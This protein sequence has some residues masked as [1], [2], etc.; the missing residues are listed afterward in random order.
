MT[1]LYLYWGDVKDDWFDRGYL[2]NTDS[3]VFITEANNYVTAYTYNNNQVNQSSAIV[4]SEGNQT[5]AEMPGNT[6]LGRSQISLA[7]L[8]I[9]NGNE[10]ADFDFL[11]LEPFAY[12]D[13]SNDNY[14]VGYNI[15][16]VEGHIQRPLAARADPC[17]PLC[18]KPPVLED[19]TTTPAQ[20]TTAVT[21]TA[22]TKRTN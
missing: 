11:K 18:P 8:G 17:P 4:L 14:Y 13:P 5:C 15:Y 9:M 6:Q 19:A 1:C 10:L 21:D 16:V 22:G 3:I 12:Q 20:D 2:S 7:D